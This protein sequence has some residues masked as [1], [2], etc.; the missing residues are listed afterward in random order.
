M[1]YILV[2]IICALTLGGTSVLAQTMAEEAAMEELSKFEQT[3]EFTD[4][5]THHMIKKTTI[6]DDSRIMFRIGQSKYLLNTLSSSC[7]QLGRDR[8]FGFDTSNSKLCYKDTISTR[9]GDCSLGQFEV[10]QKKT[11]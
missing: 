1:K 10:L 11:L 6:V 5:V 8:Q 2:S 9:F 4:C 7:R 3:G